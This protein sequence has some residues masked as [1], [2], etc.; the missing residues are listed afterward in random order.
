MCR[1]LQG[2]G[3]PGTEPRGVWRG[4][5]KAE[6][7]PETWAIGVR[8]GTGGK[9]AKNIVGWMQRMVATVVQLEMWGG[10]RGI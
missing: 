9:T 6:L 7:L 10:R 3:A 8:P 5:V 2:G 1:G 4:P